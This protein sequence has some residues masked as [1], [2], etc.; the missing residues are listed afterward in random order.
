MHKNAHLNYSKKVAKHHC[1]LYD[2]NIKMCIVVLEIISNTI[3]MKKL[4][5]YS[6]GRF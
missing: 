4:E 2:R 6:K 3:I 1:K 5:K